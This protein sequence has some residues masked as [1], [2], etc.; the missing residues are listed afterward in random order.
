MDIEAISK[1]E[2]SDIEIQLTSMNMADRSFLQAGQLAGISA[3]RG[4]E[5][6]DVLKKMPRILYRVS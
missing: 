2:I 6:R 4:D 3:K 1:N 5:M